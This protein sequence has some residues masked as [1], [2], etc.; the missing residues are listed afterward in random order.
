M[1]KTIDEINRRGWHGIRGEY[2]GGHDEGGIQ[3]MEGIILKQGVDPK[4]V[5]HTEEK[6]LSYEEHTERENNIAYKF[7]LKYEEWN[8]FP[9]VSKQVTDV[10]GGFAFD[11]ECFGDF[12]VTRNGVWHMEGKQ[13]EM[14]YE[15]ITIASNVGDE[16]CLI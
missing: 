11:G 16:E 7:T 5:F 1:Q 8:K 6:H 10:Y 14:V 13:G 15:D 9:E 4:T 3:S 2:S 12:W